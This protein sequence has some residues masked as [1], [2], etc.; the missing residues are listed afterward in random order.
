MEDMEGRFGVEIRID[1]EESVGKKKFV[2]DKG[3]N[4]KRKVKK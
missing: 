2:I 3:E 1:E 4:Y